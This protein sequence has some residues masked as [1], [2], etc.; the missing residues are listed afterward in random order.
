MAQLLR[1]LTTDE[2]AYVGLS[3][4]IGS[5]VNPSKEEISSPFAVGTFTEVREEIFSLL[6][7]DS[8]WDS[9]KD[10]EVSERDA[11]RPQ[12]PLPPWSEVREEVHSQWFAT[13]DFDPDLDLLER[14]ALNVGSMLGPTL[15]HVSMDTALQSM[16][17]NTNSGL[18][19]FGRRRKLLLREIELAQDLLNQSEPSTTTYVY[20]SRAKSSEDELTRR[21]I[22]MAP[23]SRNI[24][25]RMI[26]LPLIQRLKKTGHFLSWDGN[27]VFDARMP[28]LFARPY[29]DG[30]VWHSFDASGYDRNVSHRLIEYV[31]GMVLAWFQPVSHSLVYKVFDACLD[32]NLLTPEGLYPV[33]RDGVKSG[34][35][36]TNI[37]DSL[38]NLLAA[39][40]VSLRITG[41]STLTGRL[42]SSH[43]I[44]F[45]QINGD[46]AVFLR[47]AD[48][49]FSLVSEVYSEV[50]IVVS[51]SKQRISD[52]FF[53]FN[54]R[55]HSY[56]SGGVGV[57][58][59]WRFFKGAL[60]PERK[61][62]AGQFGETLAMIM[63]LHTVES[64]P[65]FMDILEWA[66][67][68]DKLA[69]GTK[70]ATTFASVFGESVTERVKESLNLDYGLEDGRATSVTQGMANWTVIK[71]LR[72]RIR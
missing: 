9:L 8:Y 69:L 28:S 46:D 20:G 10:E 35:G 32:A 30:V 63:R 1:D 57:R 67:S 13:V 62:R 26:F 51:E 18:P 52:S 6:D 56:N 39:E 17:L 47:R 14:A 11:F 22:Y 16:R 54:S 4:F 66:I 23:M 60:Y 15:R 36:L 7:T 70:S 34:W 68:R 64:H 55:I 25:D 5:I 3:S 38:V 19:N 40:Y 43:G 72:S 24:L 44:T 31:R 49:D 45:P 37:V 12:S 71:T 50:G 33:R 59:A 61:L 42:S 41:E 65:Q 53:R 48:T 21:T 27:E 58:S 29:Y 2:R